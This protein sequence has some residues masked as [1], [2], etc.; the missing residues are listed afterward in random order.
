MSDSFA[1]PS[2][3]AHQ[4]PLSMGFPRQEYWSGLPFPSRGIF[5]TQGW[6]PHL[7]HWQGGSLPLSHQGSPEKWC[8]W[9]YSQSRKRDTG[10]ENKPMN[11][12][13]G[14]GDG[15][16]WKIGIDVCALLILLRTYCIAKGTLL[17]ALWW[18][19]WEGNPKKEEIYVYIWLIHF[20]VQQRLTTL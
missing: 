20:A 5:L 7:L 19:K 4:A 12:K 15:M 9:T 13:W 11:T 3:V 17:S 14:R 6:N 8:R 10:A 18:P 1:T 16:N 2:A